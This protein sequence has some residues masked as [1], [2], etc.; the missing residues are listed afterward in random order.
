MKSLFYPEFTTDRGGIP[1]SYCRMS[2]LHRMGFD[3]TRLQ[4]KQ[5]G[6]I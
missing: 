1:K 3:P 5:R 6:V 4:W 2:Y